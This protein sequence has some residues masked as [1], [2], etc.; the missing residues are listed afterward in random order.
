MCSRW[1]EPFGRTSLEAASR[2]AAVIISD[3]GG[4][5]E[6]TR[7]AL[8]LKPLSSAN[9]FK[10]IDELIKNKKKLLLLQ[11]KIIHILYLHIDM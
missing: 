5:P 11:K 8:I 4:L 6:T 1:D 3:K 10:V 7:D 2:G 9:L